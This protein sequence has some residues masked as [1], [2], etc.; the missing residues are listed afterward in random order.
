MEEVERQLIRFS[1]RLIEHPDNPLIAQCLQRV[2]VFNQ[3]IG[4][5]CGPL[6]R[7]NVS[8]CQICNERV[9]ITNFLENG[10]GNWWAAGY[11]L[12]ILINYKLCAHGILDVEVALKL[13][14]GFIQRTA[15][16]TPTQIVGSI[17]LPRVEYPKCHWRN[18]R[19]SL[20]ERSTS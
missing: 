7:T 5:G 1:K 9:A 20:D 17:T 8:G 13:F 14:L 4:I 12:S 6:L 18:L 15:N 3:Y 11:I 10:F 19:V 16:Q 2:A